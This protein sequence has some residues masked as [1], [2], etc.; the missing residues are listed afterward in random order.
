M[1]HSLPCSKR[2]CSCSKRFVAGSVDSTLGLLRAIFCKLG[3][4]NDSNPVA[5]PLVE[6]YLKIIRE[7]QTGLAVRPSQAVPLLSGKF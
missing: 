5:H 4:A 2:D 7:E 1:V 3:R 6:D